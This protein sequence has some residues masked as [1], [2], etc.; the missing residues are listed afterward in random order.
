MGQPTTGLLLRRPNSQG[1][2]AS[3]GGGGSGAYSAAS[4]GLNWAEHWESIDPVLLEA[5]EVPAK[6]IMALQ[7]EAAISYFARQPAQVTRPTSAQA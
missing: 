4:G 3:S 2:L 7:F 5:L 6:R 1:S